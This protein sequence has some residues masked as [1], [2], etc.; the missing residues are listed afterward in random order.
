M[1]ALR[2]GLAQRTAQA[3]AEIKPL[4]HSALLRSLNLDVLA[5]LEPG[6]ALNELE[7][8]VASVLDKLGAALSPEAEAALAREVFDDLFGLGPLEQFVAR[9][10][11][12]EIMVNGLRGLYVD[13]GRGM[14]AHASPFHSVEDLTALCQRIAAMAGRRADQSSP[15]CDARLPGGSRVNIVLPPVALDG[16]TLTIRKFPAARPSLADLQAKGTL[17]GSSAALLKAAVRVRANILV[18]GGA[19]SGKTTLL[20]AISAF[21]GTD[22]R[23]VTCEDVAEL[24]LQRDH[25]VRLETRVANSEQTGAITMQDLVR[26]ALRMRP[27]RIVVGE[28]RGAEAFDLLTAMHTG[29]DGSMGTLHANSPADALIRLQ[30]L[31]LASEK[32]LP[33]SVVNGLIGGSLDLIAHLVRF[34]DGSRRLVQLAEIC[35]T[36]GEAFGLRPI[37]AASGPDRAHRPE[38]LIGKAHG[39]GLRREARLLAGRTPRHA[40]TRSLKHDS[41]KFISVFG[42]RLCLDESLERDADST[43]S[44]RDPGT[45]S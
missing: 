1:I 13:T 34:P 24:R 25:V 36:E 11:A 45:S 17:N 41:E 29:H 3:R 19:G 39:L 15:L 10:D 14:E 37:F 18:T 5:R 40:R 27:D 16:P 26:N 43:E 12:N 33:L 9:E 44:H 38:K 6:P 22:E 21:A 42:K 23:I 4:I 30:S 32:G 35:G 20:N 8:A 2:N 28:V 31:I 7:G